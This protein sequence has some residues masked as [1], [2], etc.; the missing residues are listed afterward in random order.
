[1]DDVADA[2]LFLM[3]LP[4]DT[5]SSLLTPHSSPGFVNICTGEE[6]TIRD[7]ALLVKETVGYAGELVFDSSKPD[8]TPRKLSDPARLQALGWR[9]RIGLREGL[10][11]TYQWFLANQ[12]A[13]KG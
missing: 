6:L 5:V 8:G 7:L 12:Q 10:A 4:E 1:M 3:T 11:D 9:H 13:F 2:S